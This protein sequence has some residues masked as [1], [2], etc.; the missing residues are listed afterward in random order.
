[1]PHPDDRT[2]LD[3]IFEGDPYEDLLPFDRTKTRIYEARQLLS[4]SV[5]AIRIGF[6]LA[7]LL[8]LGAAT[9]WTWWDVVAG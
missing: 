4:R 5:F 9:V 1:M 7:V 8:P 3:M 2:L 6:A